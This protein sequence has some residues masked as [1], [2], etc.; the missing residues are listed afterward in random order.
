MRIKG[1]M[2]VINTRILESTY[3]NVGRILA[4]KTNRD[5]YG[6]SYCSP[7]QLYGRFQD[8]NHRCSDIDIDII[9]FNL[10]DICRQKG[11]KEHSIIVRGTE[12][13]KKN[14]PRIN[15]K[16]CKEIRIADNK[17]VSIV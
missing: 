1:N 6:H 4:K 15:S 2:S 12:Y 14:L 10:M 17:I 16:R 7:F 9:N 11:N 8:N 3:D 13:L 5:T